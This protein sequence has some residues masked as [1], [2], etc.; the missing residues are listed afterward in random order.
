[1]RRITVIRLCTVGLLA[2]VAL[3][4]EFRRVPSPPSTMPD[5]NDPD[6]TR[7]VVSREEIERTGLKPRTWTGVV[8]PE[9]YV[10]LDRLNKTV[11]DLKE[12]LKK[13]RDVKAFDTLWRMRFKGMVYVQIQLKPDGKNKEVQRR[14]L[15]SLKAS[16]FHARYLF[17]GAPGIIGFATKEALDKLAKNP[18]VTGVCLD[19]N[20]LPDP[21]AG[22][23]FRDHLPPPKPGDTSSQQPGVRENKVEADVYRVFEQADRADVDVSLRTDSLPELTD[24]P[25]EM[26]ARNELRDQAE[27]QLQDRV[28][29]TLTA[30]DFMLRARF[31]S[32]IGGF[33]TRNGIQQLWKHPDVLRIRLQRLAR[34]PEIMKGTDFSR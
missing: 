20:Q 8:D 25:S 9:V 30:D 22:V 6:K 21:L 16:E 27:K 19:D 3:A 4:G 1:M 15:A 23:I 14:V 18:D 26:L 32:G 17:D 10:R 34:P 33:V 31:G 24:N 7:A 11:A 5:P 13:E 12:R 2:G 29:S 28:L